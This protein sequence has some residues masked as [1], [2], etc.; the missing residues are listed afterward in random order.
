MKAY[1]TSAKTLKTVLQH[2][3]L[4]VS[5]IEDTMDRMSDALADHKEIEDAIGLANADAMA[6]AGVSPVDE[7]ELQDELD[8][9]IQEQKEEAEAEK[10][11]IETAE[12]EAQ[13]Q[14]TVEREE[15]QG[16]PVLS[17]PSTIPTAPVTPPPTQQP[18]SGQIPNKID[19]DSNWERRYEEGQAEKAAQAIRDQ[20]AELQMRERWEKQQ[21][22]VPERM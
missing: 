4:Q 11:R 20:D 12:A 8:A 9:L 22:Q 21:Q 14:A 2:P 16:P 10:R 5:S 17:P 6:A 18:T 7:K 3:L 15:E 19:A 1:D 13:A